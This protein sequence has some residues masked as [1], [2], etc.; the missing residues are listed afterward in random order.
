MKYQLPNRYLKNV[1]R[2]EDHLLLKND[3][4][5]KC[6]ISVFKP[7]ML[8]YT[9]NLTDPAKLLAIHF[10][11]PFSKLISESFTF[12]VIY[13]KVKQESRYQEV[14][15]AA[16]AFTSS[17]IFKTTKLKRKTE[18][19]RELETF[20]MKRRRYELLSPEN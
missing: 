12:R 11:P 5:D 14:L 20:D 10:F 2:L 17:T 19:N 9:T 6:E 7:R 16:Y 18:A 4:I 8:I 15:D 13:E 3:P 1:R